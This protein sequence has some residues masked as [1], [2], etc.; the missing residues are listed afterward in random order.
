[1][2]YDKIIGFENSLNSSVIL[3]FEDA[4]AKF[5]I[6]YSKKKSGKKQF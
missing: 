5:I 2:E 1:M 3:S 4:F 6:M